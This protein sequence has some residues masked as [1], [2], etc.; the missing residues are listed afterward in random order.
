MSM[1]SLSSPL[2]VSAMSPT[3]PKALRRPLASLLG[4]RPSVV[5]T[6]FFGKPLLAA[7]TFDF[8]CAPDSRLDP[9][10]LI[11]TR[12]GRRCAVAAGTPQS[13]VH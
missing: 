1:R 11:S 9:S 12:T 13:D 4:P 3:P 10:D 2:V 6:N 7:A 8:S 5:T